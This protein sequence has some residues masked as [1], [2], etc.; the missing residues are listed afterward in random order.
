MRL[1]RLAGAGLAAVALTATLAAPAQAG[2]L[3]ET[4]TA[5]G[6]PGGVVALCP[7]GLHPA[8]WS[9]TNGDG[10][11]LGNDQRWEWTVVGDGDNGIG[12]WIAP[13]DNSPPPPPSIRLTVF[14]DC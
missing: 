1:R 6:S 5:T 3:P 12:A 8:D 11:P 10:T 13:Y 9:I 14:C 2:T 7:D 4:V